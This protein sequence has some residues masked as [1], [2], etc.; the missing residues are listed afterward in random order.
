MNVTKIFLTTRRSIADRLFEQV[1]AYDIFCEFIGRDVDIGEIIHSPIRYDKHP[2]FVLF[3]ST[4]YDKLMFKDFAGEGGDIFKFV[5]MYAIYNESTV[6]KK[7]IDVIR[8]ID[9]KLNLGLFGKG[10]GGKIARRQVDFSNFLSSK[11][12]FFKSRPFTRTDL[13]FWRKIFISEEVL[14]LYDIRSVKFLLDEDG[15][16]LYTASSTTLIFVFVIYDKVK[17]Y[18]PSEQKS[19]KWRNT[20]PAHYYQGLQQILDQNTG[21][22]KLIIT[23]SLKDVMLFHVFLGSTYD[24]LAPHGESYKFEKTFIAYINDRYDEITIIYDFDLAGV[25]G[26]NKLRKSGLKNV[27]VKFISTN[28]ARINGKRVVVDKDISDYAEFR[29]KLKVTNHLKSLNL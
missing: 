24:V 21:N 4:K 29:S 19:F 5:R 6:L 13:V 18:R 17:L 1:D 8:Y 14:K 3:Y 28:R 2:T 20:C 23:K 16:I 15:E 27:F 25:A 9:S 11:D 26:A 12:I 22:K 10:G 7:F